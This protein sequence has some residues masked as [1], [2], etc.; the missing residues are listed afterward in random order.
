ERCGPSRDG[1]PR[2]ARGEDMTDC[3]APLERLFSAGP[4]S[5]I[6]IGD[7]GNELGMGSLPYDLVAH[8]V[9]RGGLLWCSIACAYP[10]MCGISNFGGAALL[11]ATA[12]LSPGRT[13][14]ML[15]PVR[16]DFARHLLEA[17]VR[18]GGAIANDATDAPPR[19]HLFVDGLPWSSVE[20]VHR[21]I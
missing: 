11:G 12:L 10:I 19:S 3:N 5:T 6:G 9:P 7:L 8:S 4:W 18:D 13:R 1:R 16:P 20:P 2:D 15:E 21:R 14:Q 17:A